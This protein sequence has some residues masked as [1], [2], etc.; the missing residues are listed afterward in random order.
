MEKQSI[1]KKQLKTG[2]PFVCYGDRFALCAQPE[3]EDLKE[4]REGAWTDVL[5]LRGLQELESLDFE[6]S[7]LC[8]KLDLNY[9]NIPVIINGDINKE[10]LNSI[11]KLLSHSEEE[12]KFVIHCAS[13]ARSAMALTAHFIFSNSYKASELPALA[14]QLGL[15]KPEMLMSLFQVMDV[16]LSTG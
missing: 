12:K 14:E 8:Q 3:P 5:N 15:S 2:F 1:V 10:A 6:M 9:N 13:G 16:D 7:E 4:F 11:H